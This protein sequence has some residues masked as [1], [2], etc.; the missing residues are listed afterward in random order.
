[1]ARADTNTTESGYN[2]VL[3]FIGS[4]LQCQYVRK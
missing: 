4:D 2:I 1:M 3:H